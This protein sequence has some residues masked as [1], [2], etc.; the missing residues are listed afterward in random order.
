MQVKINTPEEIIQKQLEQDTEYECQDDWDRGW[1]AA[2][3]FVK[4]LLQ[5]QREY[6]ENQDH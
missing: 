4:Q 5:N 6:D 1:F 3:T 2:L